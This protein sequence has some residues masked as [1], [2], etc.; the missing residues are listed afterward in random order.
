M[1]LSIYL[2]FT[3]LVAFTYLLLIISILK[4]WTFQS[5][6]PS[7][8]AVN[9][10]VIIPARNEAYNIIP[11]LNAII[12]SRD[13]YSGTVQVIVIDDHSQDETY[14]IVKEFAEYKIEVYKLSDWLEDKINAYK[15]AAISF[16]LQKS[17]FEYIVQLDADVF[18]DKNYFFA[19][20]NCINANDTIFIAGPVLFAPSKNLLEHFQT[21]DMMGM[22]AVTNAGIKSQKW[23]MANGANMV[24]KKGDKNFGLN[25][26]ASGDD[27]YQIQEYARRDKDKI[28]FCLDKL[29][30]VKTAPENSWSDLFKQRIRW[31]TKNKKMES[32]TMQMMMLIPFVNAW[33]IIGHLLLYFFFGT[34]ALML[35]LFH[36]L[37]KWGVDYI[38]L[39]KLSNFFDQDHSMNYFIPASVL[40]LFYIAF[41][42]L[43]SFFVRKY[44]WKGRR[45][46]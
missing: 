20:N 21:L 7:P 26:M 42:G 45:V 13:N 29:A 11:C 4:E 12:D 40:H 24:Y 16:G 38:Y 1:C 34:P 28:T 17:T 2:I 8:T 9:F 36:I 15:K 43:A 30:I 39:K 10:S 37:T 23:Y 18:V 3:A 22:M 44:E 5:I 25:D 32:G 31:A 19:I 46:R 14:N 41:I 6:G 27:V 33:V 35:F